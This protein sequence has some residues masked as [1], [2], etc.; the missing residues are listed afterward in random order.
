MIYALIYAL[1]FFLPLPAG[2]LFALLTGL[3]WAFAAALGMRAAPF[4]VVAL[5]LLIYSIPVSF[6]SVTGGSYGDLPLSW[7]NVFTLLLVILASWEMLHRATL[8][9]GLLT[10]S[11]LAFTL[12]T[13]PGLLASR[14]FSMG[15][16]Q[17][18]HIVAFALAIVA[19][20]NLRHKFVEA[21]IQLLVRDYFAAA[22][23]TAGGLILQVLLAEGLGRVY[24]RYVVFGGTRNAAGFIFSDFSFLAL[25]LASGAAVAFGLLL[26]EKR[27]WLKLLLL[28]LL[29]GASVLTTA[30][31]GFVAFVLAMALMLLPQFLRFKL[32]SGIIT[33]IMLVA[34]TLVGGYY[35]VL[36][37]PEGLFAGSGR[38]AN[39]SIAFENAA[40]SPL[41]GIGLGVSTYLLTYHAEIPHNL[42]IQFLA[43]TGVIGFMGL[44]I[45]LVLLTFVAL[46]AGRLPRYIFA[47]V[48]MG[49]MFIPD[50]INS[51]FFLVSSVLAVLSYA[52]QR[53][54]AA[55]EDGRAA[56]LETQTPQSFARSTP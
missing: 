14:D 25:Y 12:S 10:L 11:S 48:L 24:G 20:E 34:L 15:L 27:K 44:L 6:Q 31:T 42:L 53:Q 35:M 52:V 3:L 50:L 55:I 17:Y 26:E 47:T 43:Q 29:L 56:A 32:W 54:Q 45:L 33:V 37:R 22:C 38:L 40:S 49:S 30:R 18:V 13:L 16:R 21:H 46:R 39:Y 4:H 51:R 41:Y 19:V 8:R 5:R 7:F 1:Y 9:V 36:L 28:G 2:T 23:L